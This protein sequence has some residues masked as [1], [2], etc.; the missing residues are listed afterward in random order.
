MSRR[1]LVMAVDANLMFSTWFVKMEFRR[2]YFDRWPSI[3]L[4][5]RILFARCMVFFVMLN[6]AFYASVFRLPE[7]QN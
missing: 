4:L 5:H 2:H 3:V 6:K 7:L 1:Q